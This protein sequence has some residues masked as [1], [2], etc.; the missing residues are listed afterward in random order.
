MKLCSVYFQESTSDRGLL[1]VSTLELLKIYI[2]SALINP[3][4]SQSRPQN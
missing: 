4:L 1:S 3:E 2:G